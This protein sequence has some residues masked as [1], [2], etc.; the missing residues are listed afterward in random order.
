MDSSLRDNAAVA[1]CASARDTAAACRILDRGARVP[2]LQSLT[3]AVRAIVAGT[4]PEVARDRNAICHRALLA[5][6]RGVPRPVIVKSPR[7]GPQRT[8][9]DATFAW[10]AGILAQLPILG[11]DSAPELIARVA[12]GDAHFLFMSELPGKHPDAR[13]HPLDA[14]QLRAIVDALQPMDRL[15]FMHYD[16]KAGNVL[17]N[18][19]RA[20]FIDFEFARVGAPWDAD[21]PADASFGEDFN[22]ANN[23]FLR[24]RSNVANFEFRCLHRHLVDVETVDPNA[25]E[26]LFRAWLAAKVSYHARMA[27]CL[28]G[29]AA[30]HER[31]LASLFDDPPAT[32]IRVERLL[33]AY[34][35]A[36][37]ERDS[38]DVLRSRRAIRAAID[39]R[40]SRGGAVPQWY[41]D[42]A[43]RIVELVARSTH[44]TP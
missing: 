41:A 37:F 39:A 32:A 14:L 34:R 24:A 42:S 44:P 38:R 17:T 13:K 35:T 21:A 26:A 9:R 6:R 19:A 16:L 23:P 2:S 12:A 1:D 15:G 20:A 22:V 7:L 25:A 29:S 33:I 18:G 4:L 27:R 36:V 5:G 28:S 8:N 30:A 31:R 40:R 3:G 11:I 10:E 43:A